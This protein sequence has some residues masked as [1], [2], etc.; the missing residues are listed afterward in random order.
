MPATITE[1]TTDATDGNKFIT[2]AE[3]DEWTK[4]YAKSEPAEYVMSSDLLDD[5][6]SDFLGDSEVVAITFYF[7]IDDDE[8]KLILTGTRDSGAD[9]FS[10][11]DVYYLRAG[12]SE[13]LSTNASTAADWADAYKTEIGGSYTTT[14]P[15][16]F[17]FYKGYFNNL[18]NQ[19]GVSMIKV[20]RGVDDDS[21][22][23]LILAA[24]DSSGNI[25]S[26]LTFQY[27]DKARPCPPFTGCGGS[28][29][30]ARNDHQF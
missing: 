19:S 18:R 28:T 2:E 7:G 17:V 27:L 14:D 23:I 29:S 12:V 21:K 1:L 13:P 30:F 5:L 24:A 20:F 10:S 6:D 9:S 26:N 4:N 25:L 8:W 15:G 11:S 16:A 22:N 3:F